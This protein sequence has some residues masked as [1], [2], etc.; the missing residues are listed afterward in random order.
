MQEC[1]TFIV[2]RE[3]VDVCISLERQP[4]S[5]LNT[6]TKGRPFFLVYRKAT[7]SSLFMAGVSHGHCLHIPRSISRLGPPFLGSA[8]EN[9]DPGHQ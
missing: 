1:M 3:E 9:S 4:G 5:L 7:F 8:R 2:V 6:K